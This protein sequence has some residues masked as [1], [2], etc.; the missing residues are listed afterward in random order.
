GHLLTTP[1]DHRSRAGGCVGGRHE[2]RAGSDL[3]GRENQNRVDMVF[4]QE[5]RYFGIGILATGKQDRTRRNK[6]GPSKM[7]HGDE[8]TLRLLARP[9]IGKVAEDENSL[10]RSS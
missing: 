3:A 4:I 7:S 8:A 6:P 2:C 9:K 1:A 5:R 10:I